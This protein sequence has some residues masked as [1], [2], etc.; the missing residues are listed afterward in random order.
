MYAVKEAVIA[1][2]HA[3]SDLDCAI[4]FMDMRT[5]GKDFEKYYERAR[6]E[7]GVRFVRTRIHSIEEDPESHSLVLKYVGENGDIQEEVFD[8]V[9]LSV[10]METPEALIN[11]ADQLEIKLDQDNFVQTGVF[12]PVETSRNGI[13]VC[14]GF[15]EPKDIPYS[16]MEASAAACDAMADLSEARG[17]LVKEKTYPQEKD[18]SCYLC[19]GESLYLFPGYPG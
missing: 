7:Q 12:N 9:V 17:S 19:R 1:K 8:M 10:G 11:T 5:Y 15:Q 3:G 14:G 2:E 13:Y 6:D 18:V 16:V 4:F